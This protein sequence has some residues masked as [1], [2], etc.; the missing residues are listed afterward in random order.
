MEGEQGMNKKFWSVCLM[1]AA[2][3]FFG[4]WFFHTLFGFL[5]TL[6]FTAFIAGV[7]FYSGKAVGRSER[8]ELR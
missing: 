6:V 4:N 1:I 5:G 7:G 8:R 3:G 2:M